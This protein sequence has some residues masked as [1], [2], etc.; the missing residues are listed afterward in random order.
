MLQPKKKIV[1]KKTPEQLNAEAYE[2][3][4][5]QAKKELAEEYVKKNMEEVNDSFLWNL[6]GNVY[7]GI[8]KYGINLAKGAFGKI[9]YQVKMLGLAQTDNLVTEGAEIMK[10]KIEKKPVTSYAMGGELT[11][12]NEGGSHSQNPNGGVPM[13]GNNTVEEGETIKNDFVYSNR[14]KLTPEIIR[15]YNLPKTLNNKTVAE[16]TKIIDSKFK[17]RS[18]KISMST[19]D[20]MLSKIA[21]AQEAM[22]PAEPLVNPEQNQMFL[23]GDLEVEGENSVP[24]LQQGL[25]A[26][27]SLASGDKEG[28]VSGGASMAGSL[29]GTAIG[30]PIGGMIGGTLGGIAG[31]LING[32][33]QRKKAR[34]LNNKNHIINSSNFSNDFAM[35]GKM[36]ANKGPIVPDYIKKNALDFQKFALTKDKNALPKF[37]ADG[38]WGNESNKAYSKYGNDYKNFL[39]NSINSNDIENLKTL[40]T[41]STQFGTY[42]KLS[43]EA[44]NGLNITEGINPQI[45]NFNQ[46]EADKIYKN[47]KSDILPKA[48]LTKLGNTLGQAAR[49][50]PIATNAYQLSQLKKPGYSRLDRLDQRFNPEYVDERSL[51][52]IVSNETNNSINALSGA[53]NGSMGALRSNILG[54]GIN[55]TK[56]MSD[57]YM[58]AEAQNRATNV[59]AQQFNAGVNQANIAQSNAE[60]DINDR[61]QAA[62]RNEKSKFISGI[63]EG[64][65]DIGKEETFKRIAK[66]TYGYKWDGSYWIKPDGTKSTDEEVKKEIESGQKKLGGVLFNKNKIK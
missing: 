15:Q 56:A 23:G 13:G 62:Y 30:G 44:Q 31:D 7:A 8:P 4:L 59:Q 14:I 35:G 65:G 18:D 55:R 57:A 25:G 42:D 21:E 46:T 2:K 28:V 49:Y 32:A 22:K 58:N 12:I 54:A 38:S 45:N 61:N 11:R 16:A 47:S 29:A 60:L 6:P 10:E 39:S 48:D 26:L 41:P 34:Q 1:Q 66:N 3:S 24:G 43:Q 36:Y 53:T 64:V 20:N 19:K 37:G 9:K 40:N 50:A 33:S 17:D 51:Q 5:K 52:N 63:G 27:T